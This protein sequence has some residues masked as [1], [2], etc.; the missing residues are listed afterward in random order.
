LI[1]LANQLNIYSDNIDVQKLKED[2]GISIEEKLNKWLRSYVIEVNID[3]GKIKICYG[4]PRDQA[5]LY[6]VIVKKLVSG[7]IWKL[8]NDLGDILWIMVFR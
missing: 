3:N 5:Q 7:P 6:G 8:Y 2:Q 4:I 1:L